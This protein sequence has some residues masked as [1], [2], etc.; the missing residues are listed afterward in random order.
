MVTKVGM[1][2]NFADALRD[3]LELDFDAIEAYEVAIERL[4]NPDY[5]MQLD[6]FKADHQRHTRE[7]TTILKA[8]NEEAPAGPSAVKQ[9]LAKGKVALGSIVGDNAILIAMLSNETDTNTAYERVSD[10]EDMW[11]DA[12]EVLKR[13]LNDERRHKAWIESVITDQAE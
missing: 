6:A 11:P 4:E 7:L 12:S 5:K 9:W 8:H 10:H 1:Q 13:G 3:L 2:S